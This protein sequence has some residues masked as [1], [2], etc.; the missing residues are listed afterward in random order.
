MKPTMLIFRDLDDARFEIAKVNANPVG[1]QIM[2]LKAVHRIVKFE[3]VDPK[4]ANIVK[5]EILSRGGD[6]AV[7]ENVAKFEK[8][9]T[10]I[11]VMGTLAQYIRLIKK[12]KKQS[13]GDCL[14]IAEGLQNLL[15]EDFYIEN[16]E[17][18]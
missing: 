11:I 17:V 7:S 14:K 5:Q 10:D 13:C 3:G 8:E 2:A 9:K 1:V 6:A 12:L 15:F 4:T 16:A 18:W